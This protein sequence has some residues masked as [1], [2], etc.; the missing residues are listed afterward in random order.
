M[1]SADIKT[2]VKQEINLSYNLTEVPPQNLKYNVKQVCIFNLILVD[3]PSSLLLSV[4]IRGRQGFLLN[5][6]NLLFMTN[7]IC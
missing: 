2:D 7:V 4:K 1:I 6:Q 3:I 5:S